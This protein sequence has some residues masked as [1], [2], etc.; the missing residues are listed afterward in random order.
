MAAGFL[1]GVVLTGGLASGCLR[2]K[3]CTEIG[4]QSQVH[5]T[6]TS[7]D[8]SIP[9]GSHVL[10]ATVD[11]VTLSCAFQVPL[12]VLPG[13]G[14]VGPECPVG[15]RVSIGQARTC[16]ETVTGTARS[17]S[18]VPIPG[19]FLEDITIVG[20]P[21]QISIRLSVDGAVVLDRTETPSYQS[22]EPNGPG[23]DPACQQASAEWMFA[24]S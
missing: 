19:Q 2:S 3:M 4:C 22:T 8:G 20:N 12:V 23:C 5:V 24:P 14:T 16:T 9:A 11:G 18:C 21:T 1:W 13:G 10:D 15:L 6:V 17:L 7:A